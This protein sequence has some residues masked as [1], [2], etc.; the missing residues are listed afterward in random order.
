MTY[1]VSSGTLHPTIPILV[2]HLW[3]TNKTNIIDLCVWHVTHEGMNEEYH[4]VIVT[5]F[6][7]H[8]WPSVTT[9]EWKQEKNREKHMQN[10]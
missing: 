3:Y 10:A 8:Q 2:G 5:L 4:N 7:L 6:Y 9:N 1:N